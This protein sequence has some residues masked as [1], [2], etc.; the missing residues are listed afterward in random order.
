MLLRIDH[1]QWFVLSFILILHRTYF[2]GSGNN[3]F[4]LNWPLLNTIQR[5]GC[6]CKTSFLISWFSELIGTIDICNTVPGLHSIVLYT[7]L[8]YFI[9]GDISRV[10][11]CNSYIPS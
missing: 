10:E 9:L 5:I 1:S 7:V 8:K 4:F 6:I 11:C 2:P 3:V